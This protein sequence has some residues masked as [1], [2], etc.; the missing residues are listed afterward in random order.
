V[1]ASGGKRRQESGSR[2]CL[3]PGE[4]GAPSVRGRF[5]PAECALG[6]HVRRTVRISRELKKRSY[7]EQ[8]IPAIGEALRDILQ[9][10]ERQVA[11]IC[12]DLKFILEHSRKF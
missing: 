7:I 8:Y 11:T 1:V 9:L 6:A 4:R 12:K 5:I 3:L 10:K 2:T